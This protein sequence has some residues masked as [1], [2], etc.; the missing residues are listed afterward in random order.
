M[1]RAV[2]PARNWHCLLL[3]WETSYAQ[4]TLRRRHRANLH[5][6]P[7]KA[8]S[9]PLS[10]P[11]QPCGP[12][13]VGLL[14]A[15]TQGSRLSPRAR[16]RRRRDTRLLPGTPPHPATAPCLCQNKPCTSPHSDPCLSS[17]F[18]RF[19]ALSLP[20]SLPAALLTAA[21]GVGAQWRLLE[22]A[23]GSF[24]KGRGWRSCGQGKLWPT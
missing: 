3:T 17:A 23:T 1:P 11:R 7:A 20:V 6:L 12:A 9:T 8:T 16:V 10:L 19:P 4:E 15:G 24:G 21:T 13:A 5:F 14:H 18:P 2:M 22:R